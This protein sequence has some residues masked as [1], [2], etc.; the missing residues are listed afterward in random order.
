MGYFV[1]TNMGFFP[2]SFD[3]FWSY[4]HNVPSNILYE[5]NVL[6]NIYYLIRICTS[7]PENKNA[8]SMP[9]SCRQQLFQ[10]KHTLNFLKIVA[11]RHMTTRMRTIMP[12]WTSRWM[13]FNTKILLH[14]SWFS[15]L[16]CKRH[17]V[18]TRKMCVYIEF[19]PVLNMPCFIVYYKNQHNLRIHQWRTQRPKQQVQCQQHH[20]TKRLGNFTLYTSTPIKTSLQYFKKPH[21]CRAIRRAFMLHYKCC[22]KTH[23]FYLCCKLMLEPKPTKMPLARLQGRQGGRKCCDDTSCFLFFKRKAW[24][25]TMASHDLPDPRT[26]H[27][28]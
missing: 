25:P 5:H 21:N 14:T 22:Q 11:A 3:L 27:R 26:M 15:A 7:S 20:K 10:R 18:T 17:V 16:F 12:W 1:R 13:V 6:Q 4:E 19:N 2:T 23:P 24:P 8:D 28:C 9:L